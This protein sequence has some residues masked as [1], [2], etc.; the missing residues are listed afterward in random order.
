MKSYFL[1]K[2]PG[3]RIL[4]SAVLCSSMFVGSPLCLQAATENVQSV[5]Q[6]RTV[7]GQ[8]L[9]SK[10]EAVI[11]AS[12]KVK[13]TT[14]GVI[15][16][17][18][19]NFTLNNIDQD[20]VLIISYVGYQTQEISL[21]GK[22]VLNIVLQE[23]TELLD[24]V[25]VIGYGTQKKASLTSAISQVKGEDTFK[26]RGVNNVAVALQGEVPGLV[27]T[28]TSTRP[29]SEGAEMKI[30]G[31]ISVNGKSSPL[32]LIDGQT[33]SLDE[34][35]QMNP[36]DIENISILKDA[37]AAI[38]GSRSASGVVLVSTKRGKKGKARIVYNGSVS[39]TIDGIQPPLTDNY[40]WLDMF[41]EAKYQDA[42]ANNLGLTTH[43]SIKEKIDWWILQ[44]GS[45]M[46]GI[47][48][49][50]KAMIMKHY[51]KHGVMVKH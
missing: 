38:Y 24:E 19:G 41:Y 3:R 46:S 32:V 43:E 36:N 18:D 28:R 6:A 42:R 10:G 30:R 7:K 21:N 23:D 35:N 37:S 26:D 49:N 31:D 22:S 27:V 8:I 39:T 45:V 50:G 15:S 13:G 48:E 4:F 16:D 51:G 9:D 17:I 29:G 33:A 40:E 2:T 11:G 1:G 5:M 25:V 34:L 44:P 20:A 14:V 12:V 47:D